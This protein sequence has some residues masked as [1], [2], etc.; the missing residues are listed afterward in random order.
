MKIFITFLTIVLSF[1]SFAQGDRVQI[2]ELFSELDSLLPTDQTITITETYEE[3][4]PQFPGGIVEF[5]KYVQSSLEYPVI[6]KSLNI[7]GRVILSFEILADGTVNKD[8]VKILNSPS[9]H[10]NKE[11]IRLIANSPEWIPATRSKAGNTPIPIAVRMA[12]PILFRID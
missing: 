11:A 2:N 9:E 6:A 3:S 1:C 7:E 10:L 8:S 4:A 5:Y 12:L